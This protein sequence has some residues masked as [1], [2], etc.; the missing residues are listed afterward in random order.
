MHDRIP[1]PYTS[2]VRHVP[3]NVSQCSRAVGSRLECRL[4]V[5]DREFRN[6]RQALTAPKRSGTLGVNDNRCA[7]ACSMRSRLGEGDGMNAIHRIVVQQRDVIAPGAAAG[8]EEA[9]PAKEPPNV[10]QMRSASPSGS[11]EAAPRS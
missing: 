11:H 10:C 3:P 6:L 1:G 2:R 4:R 8:L 5:T 9:L 7:P